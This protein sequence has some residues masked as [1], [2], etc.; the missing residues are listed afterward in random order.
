MAPD[1]T[2]ARAASW[3]TALL[4]NGLAV[5]PSGAFGEYIEPGIDWR[6]NALGAPP[7]FDPARL[8][9]VDAPRGSTLNFGVDPQTITVGTDGV[10]RY[11]VVA[12]SRQGANTALFEGIRCGNGEFRTY[13]RRNK[14]EADWSLVDNVEWQP[15]SGTGMAA[16][17]LA[18]ARAGICT[19][20]APN[21]P[22]DQMVRDL[23]RVASEIR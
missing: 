4:I 22:V 13:A 17:V 1:S 7:A 5:L 19:G 9:A 10:V 23:R 2:A 11:V 6:E 12:S 14:G 3:L 18:I 20:R 16:H 8:I 21:T 15:L